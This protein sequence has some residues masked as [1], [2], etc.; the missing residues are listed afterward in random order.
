MAGDKISPPQNFWFG[1]QGFPRQTGLRTDC[2]SY[3]HAALPNPPVLN[4]A[5]HHCS[6]Q[7]SD[8]SQGRIGAFGRPQPTAAVRGEKPKGSFLPFLASP[9]YL[10]RSGNRKRRF[11]GC[12][13]RQQRSTVRIRPRGVSFSTENQRIPVLKDKPPPPRPAVQGR[14]KRGWR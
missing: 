9:A 1:S 12:A 5:Q 7:D 3:P 4:P 6:L 8:G 14:G 11:P 13:P 2:S 10:S